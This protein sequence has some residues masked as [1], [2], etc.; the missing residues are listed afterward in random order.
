MYNNCVSIF[1]I[2]LCI[3]ASIAKKYILI[4]A[5]INYQ[6]EAKVCNYIKNT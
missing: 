1:K 5:I 3:I 6:I 2:A 4:I